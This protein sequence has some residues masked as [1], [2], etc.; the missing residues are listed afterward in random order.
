MC[1]KI[2]EHLDIQISYKI[3]LLTP[4]VQIIPLR[5]FAVLEETKF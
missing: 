4:N 2:G 1:P 3:L 5:I